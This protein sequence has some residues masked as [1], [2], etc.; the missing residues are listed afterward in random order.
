MSLYGMV[1]HECFHGGRMADFYQGYRFIVLLADLDRFASDSQ[2]NRLEP[3]CESN[4][5]LP[6]VEY[7]SMTRPG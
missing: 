6:H 7:Q 4:L 3:G 5:T 2:P 1:Q